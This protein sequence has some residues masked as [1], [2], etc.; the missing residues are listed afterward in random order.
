MRTLTANKIKANF[1]SLNPRK[2]REGR[3][4]EV[5]GILLEEI[6]NKMGRDRKRRIRKDGKKEEGQDERATKEKEERGKQ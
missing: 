6:G 1:K 3:E 4:K 2:E 5:K